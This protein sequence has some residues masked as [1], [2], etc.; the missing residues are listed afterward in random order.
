[1]DVDCC[2]NYDQR[3]NADLLNVLSLHHDFVSTNTHGFRSENDRMEHLFCSFSQHT[4]NVGPSG[5]TICC[6]LNNGGKTNLQGWSRRTGNVII[7]LS[8]LRH[9][10][11]I[12]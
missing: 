8:F 12:Y 10:G 4:K 6:S 5:Q 2:L 11:T 3:F 7:F 1:M 9:E